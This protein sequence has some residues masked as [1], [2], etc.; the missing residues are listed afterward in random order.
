MFDPSEI[1]DDALVDE[2]CTQA[3]RLTL[4]EC[5]F[6]L[7]VAE[8]DRRS[9]WAQ[10][11]PECQSC[12]HWLNWRCGISLAT[13]REQVRV[14]RALEHLP[15]TRAAFAS[16]EVSYSKV[17]A[18]SRV[19]TPELEEAM[20]DLAR[21]A[22]ASQLEQIVREFRRADSR[23]GA[24]ALERHRS[25]YFRSYTDPD[26]MVVIQARL[27]PEDGAVVLA[28]IEQARHAASSVPG[29]S[30]ETSDPEDT[31]DPE[32]NEADALVTVCESALDLGLVAQAD[33]PR[34]SVML[35]VDEAVL[36]DPGS[37]G[38]SFVEGVGAVSSH[39][40]RR[41]ACD[42]AVSRLVYRADG[43]VEPE[44]RTQAIPR[45][46]RRA[47]IARDR[48]CRFPACSRRK[49][50]DVH[51]VVFWSRGG[52]T[53]PS[54]LVTLCR[55]HHRCVHEGGY[56]LAMSSAGALTIWTPDGGELPC[57]P[58]PPHADT[59]MEVKPEG[60]GPETLRT[61]ANDRFDLEITVEGLLNQRSRELSDLRDSSR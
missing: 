25:R 34:V 15:M 10:G 26:G 6:V 39:T 4:A 61:G 29:V 57:A 59:L 47:V 13:A 46:V 11:A 14:G 20:L 5:R 38:C 43:G 12:A 42:S 31:S 45:R 3:A 27:S 37:E 44:G 16:G 60:V 24:L 52:A 48:G 30:A 56:R 33:Q 53:K 54:N 19:A 1:P 28:A 7:L 36:A 58:P 2:L 41:L 17:R 32:T 35:H 9:I 22:T 50:V 40:A 49:F 23:E 51:H 8:F 18:I 21:C 55:H